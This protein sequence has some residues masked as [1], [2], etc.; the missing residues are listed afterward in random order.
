MVKLYARKNEV[1]DSINRNH[2][3]PHY[4]SEFILSDNIIAVNSI[5]QA[6]EDV[7]LA[8]LCIPTQLGII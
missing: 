6:L 7:T 8:I 2:I 3:N 4:L 5:A 1:V